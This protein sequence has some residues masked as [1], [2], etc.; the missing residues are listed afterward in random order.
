ML[1]LT[2]LII[3]TNIYYISNDINYIKAKMD[4]NYKLNYNSDN[5]EKP[6]NFGN[7]LNAF[8]ANSSINVD[9]KKINNDKNENRNFKLLTLAENN[10]RD[11]SLCENKQHQ[12]GK[13]LESY[14]S[15]L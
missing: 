14:D 15:I 7:K 13:I 10:C 8:Q 12:N 2:V 6:N 4:F 11:N 1:F 5:M 9:T 3:T